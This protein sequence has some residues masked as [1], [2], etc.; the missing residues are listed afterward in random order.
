MFALHDEFEVVLNDFELDV[1]AVSS[2]GAIAIWGKV[3][4]P[5]ECL[6]FQNAYL[7]LQAIANAESQANGTAG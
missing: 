7:E 6:T 1:A 5:L 3:L 2:V 4:P